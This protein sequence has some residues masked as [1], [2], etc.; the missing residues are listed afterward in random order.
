MCMV[1]PEFDLGLS[2]D[3]ILPFAHPNNMSHG[4]MDYNMPTA[5]ALKFI[6]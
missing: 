4:V 3:L 6:R 1:M 2:K 5:R